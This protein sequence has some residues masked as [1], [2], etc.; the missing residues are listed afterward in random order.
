MNRTAV[1]NACSP[2]RTTGHWVA[3]LV[4]LL[5]VRISHWCGLA[6]MYLILLLLIWENFKYLYCLRL[7]KK[8]TFHSILSLDPF[9]RSFYK[10]SMISKYSEGNNN[11]RQYTRRHGGAVLIANGKQHKTVNSETSS[12][13]LIIIITP[14]EVHNQIKSNRIE[15]NRIE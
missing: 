2:N 9:T 12:I 7:Y 1:N 8:D 15:S 5:A 3:C 14:Q 4:A 11:R 13:I 6:S 10:Q